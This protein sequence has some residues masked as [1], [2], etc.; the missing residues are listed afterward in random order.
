MKKGDY[1][2]TPRFCSVKIE[3]VFKT[4]ENAL[5]AG[6]NEPTHYKNYEYGILGK[7]TG[8]NQMLF[9]GYRK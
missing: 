9:A 3:K 6:Y 8:I 2:Y 5:K 7:H 1:V 4:E